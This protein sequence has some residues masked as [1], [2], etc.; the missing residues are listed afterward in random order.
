MRYLRYLIPMVFL[1]IAMGCATQ[2][3][4]DNGDGADTGPVVVDSGVTTGR[5]SDD[6]AQPGAP[7]PGDRA[8]SL[9]DNR[10]VY[11][12]FD[13][14]VIQTADRELIRLHGRNLADN[15]NLRMRLEGHAD[16]RG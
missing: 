10:I 14:A 13:S 5:L 6:G 12:A 16:E 11:F 3:S 9:A 4:T 7:M 2:Q 1:G 8:L 15:P